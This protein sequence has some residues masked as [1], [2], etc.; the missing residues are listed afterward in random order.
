MR[1]VIAGNNYS[2]DRGVLK[3]LLEVRDPIDAK[4]RELLR[5][6]NGSLH[7]QKTLSTHIDACKKY[8]EQIEKDI[9]A[10][11]ALK[12]DPTSKS[13]TA[14]ENLGLALQK[15]SFAAGKLQ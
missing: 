7:G 10:L 13:F 12:T 1:T 4:D 9:E 3:A 2:G 5:E 6:E 8:I 14:I 11:E 15:A